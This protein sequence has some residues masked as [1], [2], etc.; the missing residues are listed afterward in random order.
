[1]KILKYIGIAV[2][3]LIILFLIV[4]ALLPKTFAVKRSITINAPAAQIF[5]N[6]NS[7]QKWE[8]WSPWLH[9]DSTIKNTYEGPASGVGNKTNWTSKDGPGTME[10]VESKPAEQIKTQVKIGDFK[11]FNAEFTFTPKDGGTEV[12][13]AASGSMSYPMNIFTLFTDKM[14]GPDYEAGLANLKK[15]VESAPAA[16]WKLAD[17][18][19]EELPAQAMLTVLDSCPASEIGKKLGEM[20]GAIGGVLR[21]NKFDFTGPVGAYY[22]SYTPEKVVF[23]AEVPVPKEIKGEG[24]VHG[25]TAPKTKVLSVMFYGDYMN[26]GKAMPTIVEYMKANKLEQNG[27]ELDYYMNDPTTVK[28]KMEIQTKMNFPIK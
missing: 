18:K 9:R 22:Y 14:M 3:A 4:A 11:P 26:M 13:W 17:Y 1:M 21:K 8:A 12:T 19:V 24:K 7:F 25:K 16:E 2:A 27:P 10:I 5:D 15:Q 6:V 28:T 23:E 20:Y